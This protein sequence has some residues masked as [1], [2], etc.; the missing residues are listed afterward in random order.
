MTKGK[1]KEKRVL[2]I[3]VCIL[4]RNRVGCKNVGGLIGEEKG[5]GRG[6]VQAGEGNLFHL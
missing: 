2:Y 1:G 5:G 6:R 3:G 4:G